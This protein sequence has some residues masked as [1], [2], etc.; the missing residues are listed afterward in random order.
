[1]DSRSTWKKKKY[2]DD[3]VSDIPMSVCLSSPLGETPKAKR[4]AQL[5]LKIEQVILCHYKPLWR[6]IRPFR[7]PSLPT[8]FRSEGSF[9]MPSTGRTS[10]LLYDGNNNGLPSKRSRKVTGKIPARKK[11][12]CAVISYAKYLRHMI[13]SKPGPG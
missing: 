12:S 1:M 2:S 11:L 3:N 7:A 4:E 5:C 13:F 10:V 8:T 6:K 9:I